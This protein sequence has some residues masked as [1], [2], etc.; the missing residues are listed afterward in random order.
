M[1]H[2]RMTSYTDLRAI[3]DRYIK[4][5][6]LHSVSLYSVQLN[7]LESLWSYI[8]H[9]MLYNCHPQ[10]SERALRTKESRCK[11]GKIKSEKLFKIQNQRQGRSK[12][13]IVREKLISFRIIILFNINFFKNYLENMFVLQLRQ[14]EAAFGNESFVYLLWFLK[15]LFFLF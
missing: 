1:L 12:L 10:K 14:I 13:I 2:G 5:S 8:F 4:T 7:T 3:T 15:N 6:F 9:I 11:G